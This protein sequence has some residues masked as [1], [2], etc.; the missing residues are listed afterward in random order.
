MRT[1]FFCYVLLM[2]FMSALAPAEWFPL[3][4]I[5]LLVA[6]PLVMLGRHTMPIEYAIRRDLGLL[7]MWL[8]GCVAIL[9]SPIPAGSKNI[10]YSIA[11]LTCYLFFFCVARAMTL[12][13][14]LNWF[15]VAKAARICLAFLSLAVIVE[16]YLASFHGIFFADIIHFAH[17]ELNAANFVNENFKRPRAFS[18]EPGFT[19]LSFECLWPLTLLDARLGR[20]R[21]LHGLYLVAFAMLA[22]AAA[23]ACMLAA[24]AVLWLARSR[25]VRVMVRFV[26]ILLLIG[27]PVVLTD[28]GQEALWVLFGRKFD[29]VAVDA[30]PDGDV[31]TL[32]DRLNSYD[33]GFDLLLK[34]PLGIGWGTLGQS[35]ADSLP[36]SDAGSLSGSGMLNLYLDVA[37]ASG[38]VGLLGWLHFVG[39]RVRDALGSPHSA[40][41]YVAVG[42]L[43]V[44]FHHLFVTEFQ[45]P[46]LWFGLLLADKLALQTR[47]VGRT[48]VHGRPQL[49]T[50]KSSPG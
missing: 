16:F 41:P 27:L 12:Q 30:L 47:L 19:A 9:F 38:L 24:L 35:F 3:P 49:A 17:K 26:A 48:T 34:H 10:N 1:I 44:T 45:F 43:S 7:L 36:V 31:L 18:T 28:A 23:L 6:A 22:S 32:F 29:I 15:D 46:F 4:L 37:V 42:L 13:A 39:L 40:A 2:P 14:R 11:M 33:I 50:G 5:L 25:D 21:W 8:C 20:H